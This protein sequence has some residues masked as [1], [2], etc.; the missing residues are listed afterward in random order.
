LKNI[1]FIVLGA[2]NLKKYGM[3]ISCLTETILDFLFA[4]Y[5]LG[6]DITLLPTDLLL[7]SYQEVVICN[8]LYIT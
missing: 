4:E 7:Q 8:A 1:K 3:A 6:T 5:V 2:K